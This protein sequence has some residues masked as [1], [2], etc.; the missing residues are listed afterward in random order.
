MVKKTTDFPFPVKDRELTVSSRQWMVDGTFYSKS[1]AVKSGD[2]SDNYTPIEH[3]ESSWEVKE[4]KRG[5]LDIVYEVTT[6]PGGEIPAWLYN[7][8]VYQ[9]PFQTMKNLKELVEEPGL[10][11]NGSNP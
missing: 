2:Q 10:A 5:L 9:G 4:S 3:F 7:M 11:K 6:E 1:S 8:A